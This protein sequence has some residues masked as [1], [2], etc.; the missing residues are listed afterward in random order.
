[1]RQKKEK[2]KKGRRLPENRFF[3]KDKSE[4]SYDSGVKIKF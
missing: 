4:I 3:A 2:D 1:L